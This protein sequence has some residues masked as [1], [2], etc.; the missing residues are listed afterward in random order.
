[1]HGPCHPEDSTILTAQRRGKGEDLV[2]VTLS[3]V[4]PWCAD[5]TSL[6]YGS[7]AR[8]WSG[9]SLGKKRRGGKRVS[10]GHFIGGLPCPNLLYYYSIILFTLLFTTFSLRFVLNVF[11]LSLF[12]AQYP[13]IGPT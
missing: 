2:D 7:G 4:L 11:K 6:F 5:C 10:Q 9:R 13:S 3:T 12:G 1:M 8:S